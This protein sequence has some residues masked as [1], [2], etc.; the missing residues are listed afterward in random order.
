MK[1]VFITGTDT[2]AGKT[3][4][5]GLLLKGFQQLGHSAY[6]LKPIASGCDEQGRN[7]DIEHLL[8]S[9][10]LPVTESDIN[11]HKFRPAIAPHLAAKQLGVELSGAAFQQFVEHAERPNAQ[12]QL[13]EG[14]GGWLLPLSQQ[15][16]LA[17]TVIEARWPVVLVVG[18]KLG[19][20]NHAL[21]TVRELRRA[22]VPLVG[23]IANIL[24]DM[25]ALQDNVSELHRLLE[26]P[27]LGVVPF[28]PT[29]LEQRGLMLAQ[30]LCSFI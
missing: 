6:A 11:W 26:V 4:V 24:G 5:C 22:N 25:P 17:D 14:A 16:L 2:D 15:E 10:T 13:I 9:A 28:E 23:F 8:A 27:C 20:L 3:F 30:Q 7:A 21:L 18:V 19:C 1:R 29:D 12:W